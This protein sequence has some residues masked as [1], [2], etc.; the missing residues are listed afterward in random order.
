MTFD[1]TENAGG[2]DSTMYQWTERGSEIELEIEDE[3][4]AAVFREALVALGDLLTEQRGGE[5]MTHQVSLA[6]PDI[7]TLFRAWL[8][9][10]ARLDKSDG[11][12]PER[13]VKLQLADSS[14]EATIGG[15]RFEHSGLVRG[16]STAELVCDDDGVWKG[17][18]RLQL[19]A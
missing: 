8:D 15:Q 11:F 14:L 17:R 9:E 5:S 6:S 4:P 7:S 13:V 10:L 1:R 12:V 2:E 19:A 16:V 3:S 18:V